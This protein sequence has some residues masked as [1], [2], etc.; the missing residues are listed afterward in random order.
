M[1]INEHMGHE[2]RRWPLMGQKRCWGGQED[3]WH[4]SQK[5]DFWEGKVKGQPERQ[6]VREIRRGSTKK[7]GWKCF[8]KPNMFN[9][10]Y[11]NYIYIIY[12]YTHNI[13]IY[14]YF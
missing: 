14:I 12:I 6:R 9:I 1:D 10:L 5:E 13:C 7:Y 2:V 8:R 4:K 11:A 3:M